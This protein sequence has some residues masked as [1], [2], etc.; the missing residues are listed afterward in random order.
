MGLHWTA[1]TGGSP[2]SIL[3]HGSADHSSTQRRIDCMLHCAMCDQITVT[4]LGRVTKIV[5]EIFRYL[6]ISRPLYYVLCRCQNCQYFEYF[7]AD[8]NSY[9]LTISTIMQCIGKWMDTTLSH[10]TSTISLYVYKCRYL[11]LLL[12]PGCWSGES[13]PSPLSPLS[14]VVPVVPV[15]AVWW[16]LGG[17]LETVGEWRTRRSSSGL[18]STQTQPPAPQ[19][20]PAKHTGAVAVSMSSS[21]PHH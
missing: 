21:S 5:C 4:D 14:P 11:V 10:T 6:D 3:H 20:A 2:Y 17:Q 8:R 7:H 15:Q 16:W 19:P 9:T 18:V 13:P 1:D 12:A